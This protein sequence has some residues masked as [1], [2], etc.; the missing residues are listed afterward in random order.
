M[1]IQTMGTIA[2]Y[3]CDFDKAHDCYGRA[4][5]LDPALVMVHIFAPLAPLAMGRLDEAR[6]A[7]D[8]ARQ[9]APDEPHIISIEGL[10]E[11]HEANF[12]RAVQLAD[13]V[14]GSKR[15]IRTRITRGTMRLVS[16]PCAAG[17][18]EPW[19]NY[20]AVRRWGYP[21]RAYSAPIPT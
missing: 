10:I 4:L 3:Q 19:Q 13:Q 16:S 1:G 18:R 11:A 15:S 6:K 5:A 12:E 2:L 17:A 14:L 21:I 9:I 7:L 20:G 8:R